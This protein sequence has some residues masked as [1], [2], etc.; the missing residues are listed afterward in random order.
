MAKLLG[1]LEQKIMDILWR[2]NRSLK[3]AEVLECLGEDLAY[4]TVMTVLKRLHDKKLLKRYKCGNHYCYIPGKAK[5]KFVKNRIG[6][7]FRDILDSYGDLAISQ[8]IDT[9]KE[10]PE[11]LKILQDYLDQNE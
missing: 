9:V 6:G 11:N 3:P 1:E 7:V 5:Q 2:E 4:T 10:D 8:F